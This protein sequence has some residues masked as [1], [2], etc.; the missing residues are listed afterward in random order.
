[1]DQKRGSLKVITAGVLA[2]LKLPK[3]QSVNVPVGS[4]SGKSTAIVPASGG[5]LI[6]NN[7]YN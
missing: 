3:L 2:L 5:R 7:V 6:L 4:I 1:M